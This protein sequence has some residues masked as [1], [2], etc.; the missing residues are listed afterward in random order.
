M[1]KIIYKCFVCVFFENVMQV[2]DS[3]WIASVIIITLDLS[4]E[5]IGFVLSMFKACMD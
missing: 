3:S 2:G 4:D 1:N 5:K